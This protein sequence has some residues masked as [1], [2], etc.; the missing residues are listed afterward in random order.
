M[1]QP[2]RISYRVTWTY[3]NEWELHVS[4]VAPPVAKVSMSDLEAIIATRVTKSAHNVRA[5]KVVDCE[6]IPA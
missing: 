2:K 6:K 4:Y 1:Q 3:A 5:I